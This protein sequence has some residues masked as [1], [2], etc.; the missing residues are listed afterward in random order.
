MT[1]EKMNQIRK[2]NMKLFPLYSM[3]S[4]DLVFFYAIK[5]LYLTNVKGINPADIVFSTGCYAFFRIFLQVPF[6]III[7]KLGYR[8]SMILG[9]FFNS[10]YVLLILCA[11]N[12]TWLILAEFVSCLAMGLKSVSETAILDDSIPNSEQKGNIFSKLMGRGRAR[13]YYF[14]AIATILAGFLFD[15]NPYIPF[16]LS[17][18]VTILSIL[19]SC[20]FIDVPFTEKKN[21]SLKNSFYDIKI[22]F[23]FILQ[24]GRL[25]GLLLFSGIMWGFLCLY[26]T[27]QVNLLND[28]QVSA[29]LIGILF[30]ALKMVAGIAATKEKEFHQR[31]R[32]KS[33]TVLG[34]SFCI[35]LILP[36][37]LALTPISYAFLLCGIILCYFVFYI[38]KGLYDVLLKRYLS[39]FTSPEILPKILSA[40]E[41]SINALKG[42]ISFIGSAVLGVVTT[43]WS[44]IIMGI[45][46]MICMVI[47][48]KYMKTRVGLKPEQYARKEI[49]YRIVR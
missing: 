23:K 26:D 34:I 33:L 32:K 45:T 5:V 14:D 47:L 25:K 8:R 20:A 10:L 4:I 7:E 24:S 35:T 3:F 28:I 43:S 15:I 39:N 18:L 12:L 17:I 2:N 36:G 37:I 6:N 16:I 11:Q 1:K 30:A 41:I 27:Y 9:N 44:M 40:N 19:L 13:Y 48:L 21:T 49:D 29:S 31:F 22:G 42:I 46:A 38:G